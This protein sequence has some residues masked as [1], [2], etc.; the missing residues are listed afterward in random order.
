MEEDMV[1]KGIRPLSLDWPER[2]KNWFFAHGGS[3]NPKTGALVMGAEI[4]E[5][6]ERLFDII[7]ASACGLFRPNREKDELTYAL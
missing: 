4:R 2:S 7:D 3:L 6:I 5:V 1:A